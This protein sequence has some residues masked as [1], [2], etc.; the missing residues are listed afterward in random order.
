MRGL[1]KERVYRT[2]LGTALVTLLLPGSTGLGMSSTVV[3]KSGCLE[4]HFPLP[5]LSSIKPGEDDETRV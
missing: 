1:S 2:R 4:V 3:R 5:V